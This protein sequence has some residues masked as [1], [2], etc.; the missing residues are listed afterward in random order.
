MLITPIPE[1]RKVRNGDAP[2]V[3]AGLAIA[4][5]GAYAPQKNLRGA[6]LTESLS[7]KQKI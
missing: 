2:S 4:R 7:A 1:Q 3:R 5:D 6:K